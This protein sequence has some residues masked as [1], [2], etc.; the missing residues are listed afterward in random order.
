MSQSA[1]YYHHSLAIKSFIKIFLP[2]ESF[3]S[4]SSKQLLKLLMSFKKIIYM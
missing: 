2:P 3:F 4:Q 1:L